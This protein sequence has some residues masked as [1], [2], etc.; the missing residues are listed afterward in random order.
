MAGLKARP[1]EISAGAVFYE[2]TGAAPFTPLVKGA[3][4][5]EFADAIPVISVALKGS[6]A[7]N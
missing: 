1:S 6:S 3:G 4:L 2:F 7:R 5:H